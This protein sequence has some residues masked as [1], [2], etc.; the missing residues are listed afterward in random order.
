MANCMFKNCGARKAYKPN[1]EKINK[2]IELRKEGWTQ[3][4]IG[5]EVGVP[6][7]T[8]RKILKESVNNE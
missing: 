8:V 3:T 6:I 1:K 4:S 5:F 2:I 7:D